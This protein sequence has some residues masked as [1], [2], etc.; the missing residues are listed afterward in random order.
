MPAILRRNVDSIVEGLLGPLQTM[1]RW[2]LELLF[3]D[4]R[5]RR[6]VP[7]SSD[8]NFARSV[9]YGIVTYFK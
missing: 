7:K 9:S 3:E 5:T 8:R 1:M 4:S 2:L 6:K